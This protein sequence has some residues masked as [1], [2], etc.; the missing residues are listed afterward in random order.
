MFISTY[1][2]ALA[3][4]LG[5]R[6]G[7]QNARQYAYGT[8]LT[9]PVVGGLLAAPKSKHW[10]QA[11]GATLTTV[12]QVAGI[13]LLTAG[14]VMVRRGRRPRVAVRPTTHGMHVSLAMRF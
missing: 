10:L 12:G 7:A 14:V 11:A 5:Q 8:R 2:G 13:A 9:I 4:G 6:Q 1:A 3:S